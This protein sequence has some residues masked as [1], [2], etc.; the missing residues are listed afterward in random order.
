[1][2]KR[3]AVMFMAVMMM[4]SAPLTV[5]AQ[6]SAEGEPMV[7][8]GD[9]VDKSG[10]DLESQDCHEIH[11]TN[12]T[13]EEL[14]LAK[15]ILKPEN[16]KKVLSESEAEKNWTAF[17]FDAYVYD[18]VEKKE[19][20]WEDGDYHF[21]LTITFKVPGIKPGDNVKVLHYYPDSW[22]IEKIVKVGNGEVTV[23]FAHL[24]PVV[25]MVDKPTSA[26]TGTG[27]ST[28]TSPQTGESNV[29]LYGILMACISLAGVIVMRRKEN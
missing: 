5:F 13:G 20:E 7:S 21:P 14:Q 4:M 9:V 8:V 27:S 29:M 18:V 16:L 3:F 28:P 25:I 22:H 1:M 2:K 23:S 24:S 17:D 15:D 6:P 26:G 12:L 19:V 11:V 10:K